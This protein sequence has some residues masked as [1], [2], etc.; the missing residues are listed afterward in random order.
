MY[1]VHRFRIAVRPNQR[2][3]QLF[4]L[5]DLAFEV[6]APIV[7]RTIIPT[8]SGLSTNIAYIFNKFPCSWVENK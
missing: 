2:N 1:E 6:E 8:K 7:S 4:L 5:F 3:V